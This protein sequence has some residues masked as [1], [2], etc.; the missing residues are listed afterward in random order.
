MKHAFPR[1]IY[2]CIYRVQVQVYHGNDRQPYLVQDVGHDLGVQAPLRS[3]ILDD[4]GCKHHP[5]L[6][7][8]AS[9]CGQGQKKNNL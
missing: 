6:L 1:D 2:P 9:A 7:L 4:R 8:G 3:C 5:H